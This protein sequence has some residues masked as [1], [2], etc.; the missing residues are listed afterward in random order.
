MDVV[1]AIGAVAT[2]QVGHLEGDAPLKPVV[3][4]HI[5]EIKQ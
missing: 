3:I 1:D 4:Q 5:V 2:G